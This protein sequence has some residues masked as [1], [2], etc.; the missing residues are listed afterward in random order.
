LA[1]LITSSISTPFED[2]GFFAELQDCKIDFQF[3]IEH[4]TNGCRKWGR[5]AL[6]FEI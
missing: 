6:D 4:C 3:T 2:R 5:G 1:S